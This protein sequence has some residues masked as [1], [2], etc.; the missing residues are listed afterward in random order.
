MKKKL[1]IAA[2]VLTA[3]MAFGVCG[4]G[5]NGSQNQGATSSEEQNGENIMKLDMVTLAENIDKAAQYDFV[6][7]KVFGSAYYVYQDGVA[8]EKCYGDGALNADMPITNTSIFRLASMTKPITAMA[9]LILVE[10][11]ALSLDDTIDTYLPEFKDIKIIQGSSVTT[12]QNIPTIRSLLNHT[13]GIGCD[14][15][16]LVKM[17]GSDKATLDASIAFF[18]KHG[19]DFEPGSKQ[20]YS[21]FGAFDVLTKIIEKVSGTD[22]LSFLQEYLFTPC[23]MMDTTFTPNSQQKG[24]MVAMHNRVDGKNTV[25]F[26]PNG[27]VYADFPATH[28]MG[29]AGL[30]STLSDYSKFAEMLLNKGKVGK[31]KI[32]KES[33]FNSLCT[34]QV[35]TDIMPGHT[36]WGLG[37]RVISEGH[38]YM[39]EGTFGWSGAY[40]SHFWVDPANKIFAVYMKNSLTDGGAGNESATKFEQAVYSSFVME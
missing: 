30:V 38:P 35:S 27:C 25:A 17:T 29:G 24:R 40:G 8:Y 33:T 6:T 14:E 15:T 20:Q 28:Y 37:V 34:P 13:S 7:N 16:K 3:I 19:L 31:S 11:G 39:P 9:T 4:A 18:V 26:M 22:Y 21:G 2:A 36:Q 23:G 10:S 1:S 5:C 12:P 32:V